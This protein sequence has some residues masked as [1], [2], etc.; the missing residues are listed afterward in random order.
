MSLPYVEP[1]V[2]VTETTSSSVTAQLAA[3]QN[4]GL[5]GLSAGSIQVTDLVTFA[6]GPGGTLSAPTLPGSP[7]STDS[8]GSLAP[9]AYFYEVAAV[10]AAD[11]WNGT[12]GTRLETT[13]T[14]IASAVTVAGPRG[15]VI[16][17]WNPVTN[18]YKYRVYRSPVGGGTGS[19]N[20]YFE[21]FSTT[22]IDAG[23]LTG[24]TG[25][26]NG[27]NTATLPTQI[28]VDLPTLDQSQGATLGTVL[29]VYSAT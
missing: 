14:E 9:G 19:E 22:F 16:F 13:P 28:S 4:V 23:T 24:T 7:T 21:V 25:T 15:R 29:S 11:T 17:N 6:D 8:S 26:A 10:T 20:T 1:G 27:S 5:V 3:P 2:V 18:A 12:S